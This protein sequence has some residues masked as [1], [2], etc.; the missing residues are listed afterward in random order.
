MG[1]RVGDL[2]QSAIDSQDF[3]QLNQSI[4]KAINE[5]L[6]LVQKN[7]QGKDQRTGEQEGAAEGHR[8][9]RQEGNA[10]NQKENRGVWQSEPGSWREAYERAAG[11]R[12]K[13]AEEW[14]RNPG[15]NPEG[16]GSG[17]TRHSTVKTEQGY[18]R[19]RFEAGD[20]TPETSVIFSKMSKTYKGITYMAVGYTFFG[21]FGV[22]TLVFGALSRAMAPFLIPTAVFLALSGGFLGMA[23]SG[24][25]LQARLRRQK[26]Y[27]Q[28]MGERDTCTL[29]EL[30]AGI[31]KSKKYVRKDLR[32]MIQNHMFPQGAYLDA[33]ETCL[34]TSHA[35]YR[36][37]LDA[38]K[39]YEQ[40][41]AEEE[42]A[43]RASAG[44]RNRDT[45][46][47]SET[48]EK[49]KTAPELSRE[50]Q[51][52][53]R[54]GKG[55]IAHIHECNDAL[56][57][58]EISDKLD[59]L[60][61]VV[62]KIFD[63]VERKPESAPDLRKMMSYY[64]PIT[65]KLVDAYRDLDA[66]QVEGQNIGKTKKEIED[67]LDTVNTAF[68]NLLDSFFQNTAWDISSDITVLHTMMAQDGLMKQDFDS[69]EQKKA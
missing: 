33:G 32:E 61:R 43:K 12:T 1:T 16:A 58:Q 2:V 36:Q 6:D 25:K 54:E 53:L 59:R 65:R 47:K 5:T 9:G 66:Q 27:L 64:L 20:R 52:I 51:E 39:R 60:E 14:K 8:S 26:H 17:K 21:I 30:A 4:T 57:G 45:E 35:A 48:S 55:F 40:R 37:Y 13:Y 44:E 23:R 24:S 69:K 38:T 22:L 19:I 31:G 63:Q 7:I 56:P 28:I 15:K 18:G 46:R 42:A 10:G 68:E 3:Q 50:I 62:S 41:K 34:M 49:K 67:S 29:E 11:G